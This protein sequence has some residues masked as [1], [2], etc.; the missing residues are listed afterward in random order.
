MAGSV[1]NVFIKTLSGVRV[2]LSVDPE[3]TV[4]DLKN[5]VQKKAEVPRLFRLGY[6]SNALAKKQTLTGAG[7]PDAAEIWMIAAPPPVVQQSGYTQALGRTTRG[8]QPN[9]SIKHAIDVGCARL[10]H[11]MNRRANGI[12]AKLDAGK[13]I[14]V[15]TGNEVA[16]IHRILKSGETTRELGQSCDERT[17]QIKRIKTNIECERI[18]LAN[19]KRANMEAK[20]LQTNQIILEGAMIAEGAV[21]SAFQDVET[22]EDLEKKRKA[23][24]KACAAKKKSM[25]Q[26]EEGPPAQKK[27][28]KGS[29]AA[30]LQ[31]TLMDT[32]AELE[33]TD[34]PSEATGETGGADAVL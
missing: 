30:K 7:I 28:R 14:G 9:G 8:V 32:A 15:A 16:A 5:L 33:T 25:R 4:G 27:P 29:K 18:G 6:K 3:T 10:A 34:Q 31:T 2:P 1:L 22:I 19:E 12:E 17:I 11:T 13:E 24:N 23:Y 20:K 26:E 21:E